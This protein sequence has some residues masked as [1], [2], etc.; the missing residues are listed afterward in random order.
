MTKRKELHFFCRCPNPKLRAAQDLSSYRRL[1][2]EGTIVG[3]SSPCYLYYLDTPERIKAAFPSARILVSLRDPVARFWSH[4]LMNEVY[5]S[6]GR[7]PEAI[8]DERGGDGLKDA[9]HDL[10]GVGLYA[11]QLTR[12]G[13]V[14]APER[15]MVVFLEDMITDPE[16]VLD[17]TFEFMSVSP[18]S[19][20]TAIRD[21]EYVEPRGILGR[22]ALRQPATRRIGKAFLP[23]GIRR[24]LRT[25]VLGDT[26]KKPSPPPALVERLQDMYRSDS[27]RLEE[28]LQRPLPWS[29][30]RN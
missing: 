20:N 14:F 2:G 11:E 7:S 30:H 21:K 15:T 9:I 28:I 17:R 26:S 6:R 24:V 8:L 3:E 18:W 10:F 12:W 13:S 4:Y 19:V 5:R 27:Q 23:T 25:R 1:F 29:W 16:A 22:L